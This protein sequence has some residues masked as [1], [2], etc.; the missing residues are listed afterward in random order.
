[1]LDS[2]GCTPYLWMGPG[3]SAWLE[4]P[5]DASHTALVAVAERICR[6]FGGVVV[7]RYPEQAEEHG[8]E[9]WWVDVS[10]IRLMLMRKPPGMPVGV[11]AASDGVDLLIRIASAFGI[12]GSREHFVGWR[13]P[14]WRAWRR[15]R[16]WHP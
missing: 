4:L 6:E 8:K 9:Y 15:L 14:I 7:E 12:G 10:G 5:P 1:M 16:H 13:W 2:T 11:S 3:W